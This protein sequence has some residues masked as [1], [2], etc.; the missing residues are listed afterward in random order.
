MMAL[1]G[2]KIDMHKLLHVE[3]LTPESRQFFE[4]LI[5]SVEQSVQNAYEE[6]QNK[7]IA[8]MLDATKINEKT[9]NEA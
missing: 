3:S 9:K 8:T 1:R 4:N 5:Q 2:V 7:I 6:A